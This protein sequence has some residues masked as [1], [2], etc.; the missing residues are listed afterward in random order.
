MQK[1]DKME[2]KVSENQHNALDNPL[3]MRYNS[4]RYKKGGSAP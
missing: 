3:P 4:I 1:T 2:Q